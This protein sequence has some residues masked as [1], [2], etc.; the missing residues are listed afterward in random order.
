MR[1]CASTP[2]PVLLPAGL[3]LSAALAA[4]SPREEVVRYL[5][6]YAKHHTIDLRFGTER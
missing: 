3:Q 2:A 1:G 6:R 4:I 5:K